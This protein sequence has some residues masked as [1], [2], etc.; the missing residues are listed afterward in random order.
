MHRRL[1]VSLD[2]MKKLVAST[3]DAP[4][5][6]AGATHAH[7]DDCMTANAKRLPHS[8]K[9]YKP[10]YPGK[11]VHMDIVGPLMASHIH[12]GTSTSSCSWTTTLD[13]SRP[14]C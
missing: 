2:R 14:T 11:I 10:S 13:S 3:V 1:H 9:K 6:L 5:S 7:C 8:S 4:A 12:T